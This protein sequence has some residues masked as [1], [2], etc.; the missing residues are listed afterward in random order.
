MN[1]LIVPSV[2]FLEWFYGNIDREIKAAN[3]GKKGIIIIK[4]NNL[5]EKSVIEKLYQA[6]NAGVKIY[7]IVRAICCLILGVK[8]QSENIKVFSIVGKYLEHPRVFYFHNGGDAG[9]WLD[10]AD[11][12]GRNI[13]RRMQV[14][15]PIGDFASLSKIMQL[16]IFQLKDIRKSRVTNQAQNNPCL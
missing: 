6:S 2:N 5:E 8:D 16:L 3:E 10:S 15:V 14:F 12:L 4:V 9:I 1:K 11:L 7:L 13:Y